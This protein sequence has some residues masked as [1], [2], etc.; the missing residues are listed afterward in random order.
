MFMVFVTATHQI[1]TRHH[2]LLYWIVLETIKDDF[3]IIIYHLQINIHSKVFSST[4]NIVY[5]SSVS[6]SNVGDFHARFY[7]I[8]AIDFTFMYVAY[9]GGRSITIYMYDNIIVN[10]FFFQLFRDAI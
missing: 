4:E 9:F 8:C 3:I 1:M 6:T 10:L 5:K 7:N 2:L